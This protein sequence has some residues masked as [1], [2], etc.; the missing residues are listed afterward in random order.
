MCS[1]QESSKF[2]S[3]L[4]LLEFTQLFLIR[5]SLCFYK[6]ATRTYQ[7]VTWVELKAVGQVEEEDGGKGDFN[8]VICGAVHETRLNL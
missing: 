2:T 8:F 1:C 4:P 6:E 7:K 5:A 3:L